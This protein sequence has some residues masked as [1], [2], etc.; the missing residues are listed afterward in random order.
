MKQWVGSIFGRLEDRPF[1][2]EP[3][4]ASGESGDIALR[5]TEGEESG[6]RG[7]GGGRGVE[8]K[9]MAAGGLEARV[10]AGA[11]GMDGGEKIEPKDDHVEEGRDGT[12]AEKVGARRA[13]GERRVQRCRRGARG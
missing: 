13:R 10:G 6:K 9:V 11:S 5:L 1:W 4:Q 2:H 7:A 3:S 12:P 8:A